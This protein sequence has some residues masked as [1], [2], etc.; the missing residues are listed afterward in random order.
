MLI[1][2][3]H[4]SS[5]KMSSFWSNDSITSFGFLLWNFSSS[6]FGRARNEAGLICCHNQFESCLSFIIQMR[7]LIISFSSARC[8]VFNMLDGANAAFISL[9]LLYLTAPG[10]PAAGKAYNLRWPSGS[11]EFLL[12][13]EIFLFLRHLW[14]CFHF[15]K[16]QFSYSGFNFLSNLAEEAVQGNQVYLHYVFHLVDL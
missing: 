8:R 13:S 16:T 15:A 3:I 7:N 4:S 6:H 11:G 14:C 5:V 2:L 9:I 12:V 1:A 10:W